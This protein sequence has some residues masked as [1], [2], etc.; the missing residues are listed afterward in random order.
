MSSMKEE[1]PNNK[2]SIAKKI[3][4]LIRQSL[5]AHMPEGSEAYLYGSRA[6]GDARA[7]SDWDVLIVL[8]KKSLEDSDYENISY[9]LTL[10]GIDY[11]Q[12]INP[13]MY[14]KEKWQQSVITP[15]YHN[16]MNEGI[17]I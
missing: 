17:R 12:E 5:R 11:G 7:D 6:R 13:I 16:V 14:T 9:P 2:S 1:M 3:L 4:L 10:M 8:N 15:F